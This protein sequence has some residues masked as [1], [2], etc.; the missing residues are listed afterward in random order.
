MVSCFRIFRAGPFAGDLS[1]QLDGEMVGGFHYPLLV[2]GPLI[3]FGFTC[4]HAFRGLRLLVMYNP[5]MRGRWA[6]FLKQHA[7]IKNLVALFV[8]VEVVAWSA[9]AAFGLSR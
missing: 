1:T 5:P 3:L 4:T 9:T 2:M 6:R 7:V 8:F